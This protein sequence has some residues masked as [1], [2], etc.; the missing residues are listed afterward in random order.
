[1]STHAS[2]LRRLSPTLALLLGLGS[3]AVAADPVPTITVVSN[4]Q[5]QSG[6]LVKQ[7]GSVTYTVTFDQEVF[8]ALYGKSQ[9]LNATAAI[10]TND[11]YNAFVLTQTDKDGGAEALTKTVQQTDGRTFTVT[12]AGLEDDD[13]ITLSVDAG[14][15]ATPKGFIGAGAGGTKNAA[16]SAGKKV[17]M[18]APANGTYWLDIDTAANSG[19][20][21]RP[22]LVG[23]FMVG[24][25]IN[26]PKSGYT[27]ADMDDYIVKL[28]GAATGEAVTTNGSWFFQPSSDITPLGRYTITA[29]PEDAAGNVAANSS[30]KGAADPSVAFYIW[31]APTITTIEMVDGEAQVAYDSS[32]S[33]KANHL[34]PELA[35]LAGLPKTT[36]VGGGTVQVTIDIFD[37]AAPAVPV[38]N[39]VVRTAALTDNGAAEAGWALGDADYTVPLTS[40]HTYNVT[41]AMRVITT[42]ASPNV[43]TATYPIQISTATANT[44]VVDLDTGTGGTQATLSS[45]DNTPSFGITVTGDT[46]TSSNVLVE[47]RISTDG[48]TTFGAW[49]TLAGT[50]SSEVFT[51]SA[52]LSDGVY[53]IRATYT[54]TYGSEATSTVATLTIGTPVPTL[55]VAASTSNHRPTIAISGS[56]VTPS[57][58]SIA[59]E[60]SSDGGTT[61]ATRA[62]TVTGSDWVPNVA[63]ADGTFKF[64]ATWTSGDGITSTTSAV[65]TTTIAT[66]VP[67][68]AA[69]ANADQGGVAQADGN[70]QYEVSNLLPQIAITGVTAGDGI[71]TVYKVS[72]GT[73]GTT[74][75]SPYAVNYAADI[76]N[77]APTPTDNDCTA[78]NIVAGTFAAGVWTPDAALTA[79]RYSLV[80]KWEDNKDA[81]HTGTGET[82]ALAVASNVFN[83]RV[84]ASVTPPVFTQIG[85]ANAATS[86]LPSNLNVTRA[87]G[88]ILLK[89][90]GNPG[91]TLKLKRNGTL[92]PL[93]TIANDGTWEY[94]MSS[95]ADADGSALPSGTNLITATQLDLSGSE[96]A[97]TAQTLTI[98]VSGSAPQAPVVTIPTANA[99]IADTTPELKGTAPANTTVRIYNA[100]KVTTAMAGADN[101]ITLTAR[102]HKAATITLVDPPGNNAALAVS[103]T[104][105]DITV[106]LATDG[107]SAITT[108]ATQ[109]VAAINA[110][111]VASALVKA[112]VKSG[113]SGAG[114][115][116]ALASTAIAASSLVAETTANSVGAWSK[117]DLGTLKDNTTAATTAS[118]TAGAEP[119][120][121]YTLFATAT[122]A[123]GIE[124]AGS[125]GVD[126]FVVTP[127]MSVVIA[128]LDEGTGAD[129]GLEAVAAKGVA[130]IKVVSE[131]SADGTIL[132]GDYI[133]IA[134]AADT[135]Q[136]RVGTVTKTATNPDKY[137]LSIIP[138]LQLAR[139]IGD[140]ITIVANP[141]SPTSGKSSLSQILLKATFTSGGNPVDEIVSSLTPSSFSV[142]NGKVTT[143]TKG[144]GAVG[145]RATN[146]WV[147]AVTPD[148][149]EAA[150][151]TVSL[152]AGKVASQPGYLLNA[153]DITNGGSEY[154]EAN[155]TFTIGGGS[156]ASIAWTDGDR[157]ADGDIVDGG[158]VAAD[159]II[160]AGELRILDPG[161]G[162]T[163]SPVTITVKGGPG[164]GAVIPTSIAFASGSF[165]DAVSTEY[166]LTTQGTGYISGVA[167]V[168]VV[169]GG[170]PTTP[171]AF[172]ATVA[173]GKVT[174]ITMTN[175]GAGYTSKPT[176]IITSGRNAVIKATT[177]AGTVKFNSASNTYTQAIDR[178][179]P[180]VTWK[181]AADTADQ[182]YNVTQAGAPT[183]N[184]AIT[185][186]TYVNMLDPVSSTAFKVRAAFSSKMSRPLVAGDLTVIGATA[187]SVTNIDDDNADADNDITTGGD[188][189][190]FDILLTRGAKTGTVMSVLV[191]A[192]ADLLDDATP[193]Q[194]NVASPTFTATIV[195]V[196]T[197][198]VI[199]STV[200][201]LS[202]STPA[203]TSTYPCTVKF[204]APV[205]GF[206]AEKLKVT[207]G[208]ISKFTGTGSSYT[209][210]LVPGEGVVSVQYDST[211]TPILDVAGNAIPSS[212]VLSRILDSTQPLVAAVAS[213]AFSGSGAIKPK[214]NGADYNKIA[215][216]V[217]F[218]EA[219][220]TFPATA[221]FATLASNGS[222]LALS[223]PAVVAD[224]GGKTWS[225]D[226]TI[227]STGSGAV[228]LVLPALL[229]PDQAGNQGAAST[230]Y[231][232]EYDQ[233][234]GTPVEMTTS[235]IYADG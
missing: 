9:T 8:P 148:V 153:F 106:S 175:K 30:I 107:S 127:D 85:D 79:G 207:N 65:V 155:T 134:G 223:T 52:A 58:S 76:N 11:L 54:N 119:G 210:T 29:S 68:L 200:G 100:T 179:K 123:A 142:T 189:Q 167:K 231:T 95:D 20:V 46:I 5:T 28:S 104:G 62:G 221:I 51:P 108:T 196:P 59:V 78:G 165:S 178:I 227:P 195:G 97:V 205:T 216:R 27:A 36:N 139:A 222:Q 102:S 164:S 235:P 174:K 180:V 34:K 103:V 184:A 56:G 141:N 45:T 212:N 122:S 81:N 132:S 40:G 201:A 2:H 183:A 44:P 77:V 64:R 171:A 96:S 35:G 208:V 194:A 17:R 7:G 39:Q 140:N 61:W 130:T 172:T 91:A 23:S 31:K 188:N 42:N 114:V 115:V 66:P 41:L 162:F 187:T 110:S 152:P 4:G 89:G 197:A 161:Y 86:A 150:N 128:D 169:G 181:G 22:A 144:T 14:V 168:A 215:L 55:T 53:E 73:N 145:N 149:T 49:G 10:S 203:R 80:A 136:Y 217:T 93:V 173:S 69:G 118:L 26:T 133:T 99:K 146:V 121:Q 232:I 116:T 160:D 87:S 111:T 109:L 71:L 191:K 92:L 214:N 220:K 120:T 159:G 219:P 211:L 37:Q 16:S 177:I 113:D 82:N 43:I 67:V 224:T 204:S 57:Q 228:N 70:V 18:L 125:T 156:A 60:I 15:P 170:T 176:L 226:L 74:A 1:M 47:R 94:E 192:M 213:P 131:G 129:Y 105:T 186:T 198:P 38:I 32:T 218:T 157:N 84:L 190:N 158:D 163:A 101:D 193:A 88:A 234:A 21:G 199:A 75:I 135:T 182:L 6:D 230:V 151:L 98:N 12:V 63:L 147:L 209:F 225:F 24:T 117:A 13:D 25:D 229:V 90:T 138:G 154:T 166:A 50:I 202:P 143:V 185:G 33:K 48:G 112:E 19:F 72:R 126:V 83:I 233:A 124:G 206:T 137:T 3:A